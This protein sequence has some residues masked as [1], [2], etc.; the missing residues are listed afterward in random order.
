MT[1]D[2]V[3]SL[4]S[5]SWSTDWAAREKACVDMGALLPNSTLEHRLAELL[6]DPNLAVQPAAAEALVTQG[7]RRGLTAV[8]RDLGERL[9]DPDADHIAYL[10]QELQGLRDMPILQDARA[11]VAEGA[12]PSVRSGLAELEQLFGHCARKDK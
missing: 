7:G 1:D 10:L 5:A 12:D 3:N 4:L 8:L 2:A 9:E 6:R 11:I